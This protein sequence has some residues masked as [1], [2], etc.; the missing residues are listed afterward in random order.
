LAKEITLQPLRRFHLDAAIVFADIMTPLEAM[1]VR[2]D[3]D[4]GPKLESLTVEEVARLPEFDPSRVEY[5]YETIASVRSE[6]APEVA[7]IGFAGGPVTHH[8]L[9]FPSFERHC[10]TNPPAK[11]CQFWLER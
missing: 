6:L 11:P 4:P 10:T 9:S 5:L 8:A 3:F 1:G 2:V 7:V